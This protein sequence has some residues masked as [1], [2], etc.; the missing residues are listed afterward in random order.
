MTTG[1]FDAPRGIPLNDD[2]DYGLCFACGQQNPHGLKLRFEQ[3]GYQIVTTYKGRGEHQGFP[4]FLHGAVITALVDEVMSRIPVL[5]NR[6]GMSA[7]LDIR[8]RLPIAINQLVTATAEKSG[9]H[10]NFITTKAW[11][12]LD[13]DRVAVE[14]TG[15]Y[16]LLSVE[17]LDKMALGFPKLATSWKA[18][19]DTLSKPTC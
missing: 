6:W 10:G 5:E 9:S 4:G 19:G 11:V 1:N 16:A 18:G 13:D 3:Q 17:S 12:T 14:A 7:R 8:F 15:S 2:S